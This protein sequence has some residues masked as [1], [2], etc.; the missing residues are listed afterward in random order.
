[1]QRTM[2]HDMVDSLAAAPSTAAA[3]AAGTCCRVHPLDLRRGGGDA[4]EAPRPAVQLRRARSPAPLPLSPLVAVLLV[5]CVGWRC[6]EA[7]RRLN[8]NGGRRRL[9]EPS[10]LLPCRPG[11]ACSVGCS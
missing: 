9:A 3:A 4:G 6:A 11:S 8:E 7:A 1:M 2:Q 10:P 5:A